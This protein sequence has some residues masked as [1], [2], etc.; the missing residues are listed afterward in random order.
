MIINVLHVVVVAGI[1]FICKADA[2]CRHPDTM[3]HFRTDPTN[4]NIPV[5]FINL[6]G[7]E[8]RRNSFMDMFGCLQPVR[9]PGMNAS[10]PA[11][12]KQY[13]SLGLKNVPGVAE[14]DENEEEWDGKKRR[15]IKRLDSF[16]YGV[17]GCTLGH[18]LA[19]R[20]N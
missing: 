13:L 8:E 14:N 4:N 17:L 12:V 20:M 3:R 18:L 1:L 10:D 9:I 5:Y 2:T 16:F 6:D 15:D 19:A 7:A 11:I